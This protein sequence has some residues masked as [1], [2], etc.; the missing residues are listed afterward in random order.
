[1]GKRVDFNCGPCGGR[2]Y[3]MTLNEIN[4]HIKKVHPDIYYRTVEE[5]MD[6][7]RERRG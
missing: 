3:R 5:E 1:M 6:L 4:E 7:I 2:K